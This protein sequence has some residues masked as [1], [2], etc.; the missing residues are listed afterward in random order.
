MISSL[1]PEP[2]RTSLCQA[3]SISEIN[4]ITKKIKKSFPELYSEQDVK[5]KTEVR[6]DL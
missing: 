5:D 1:I 6:G 2:Y 4:L 3:K